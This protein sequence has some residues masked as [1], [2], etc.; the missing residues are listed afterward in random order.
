MKIL[1]I[2]LPIGFE[3]TLKIKVP[4]RGAKYRFIMKHYN[5]SASEFENAHMLEKYTTWANEICMVDLKHSS[6][7]VFKS[8]A[9]LDEDSDCDDLVQT[10]LTMLTKQPQLGEAIVK[11]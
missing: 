2:A 3:G 9:E 11:S 10:I 8:F 7:T 4:S 5:P 1:D 6:G